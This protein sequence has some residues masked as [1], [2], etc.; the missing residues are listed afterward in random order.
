M[1]GQNNDWILKQS[2]TAVF[3]LTQCWSALWEI[4]R[5]IRSKGGHPWDVV[6]TFFEMESM[7]S[8]RDLY[9]PDLILFFDG[10][11]EL[12]GMERILQR[13]LRTSVR[14]E[15]LEQLRKASWTYDQ[16]KRIARIIGRRTKQSAEGVLSQINE[17]AIMADD[18]CQLTAEDIDVFILGISR[19]VG[20]RTEILE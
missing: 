8:G 3:Y 17:L 6:D 13:L 7:Y 4:E 20:R 9:A 18:G 16:V 5:L 2:R 11:H 15:I 1:S 10:L 19:N 12:K 14:A